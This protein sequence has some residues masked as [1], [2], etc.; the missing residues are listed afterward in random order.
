MQ[1]DNPIDKV[2]RSSNWHNPRKYPLINDLQKLDTDLDK[3]TQ[4]IDS[5]NRPSIENP[6]VG[7][8]IPPLGTIYHFK[9]I[10]YGLVDFTKLA[11]N[12]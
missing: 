9:S 11:S 12:T 7:G 8:S 6:R 10:S 4:V 2:S 5:N 1:A 3:N